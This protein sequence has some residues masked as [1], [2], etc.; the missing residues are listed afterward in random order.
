MAALRT[1]AFAA[2]RP[3][4]RAVSYSLAPGGIVTRRRV[5]VALQVASVAVERVARD[6][7]PERFLLECKQLLV[8]PGF[9]LGIGVTANR[10]TGAGGLQKIPARQR[11]VRSLAHSRKVFAAVPKSQLYQQFSRS[12]FQQFSLPGR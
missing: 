7:K 9:D 1:P 3:A 12:A 2:R 11:P 6:V 10:G 4:D 8:P 5:R